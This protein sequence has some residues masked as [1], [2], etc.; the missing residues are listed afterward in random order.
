VRDP[1]IDRG[2][3]RRIAIAGA[4]LAAVLLLAALVALALPSGV[5][6]GPWLPL[7][8]AL[9]GGASLAIAAVLPFFSTTL[10]AAPPAPTPLRVAAMLL[11]AAGALVAVVGYPSGMSALAAVGAVVFATG[12]A[13]TGIAAFRPLARARRALPRLVLASYAVALIDV[14]LGAGLV[15]LYLAGW[16]PIVST[17]PLGMVAHAWLN[18]LGFVSLT[19]A[20]TLVHLLPTVLGTRIATRRSSLI[21]VVGLIVGA[22]LVAAG[23]LLQGLAGAEPGTAVHGLADLLSRAGALGLIAGAAGLAVFAGTTWR[24]RGRWTTDR[25]WH[26]WI[27][28]GLGSSITWFVVAALAAGIPVILLGAD[29]STWSPAT[30]APLLVGGWLALAVLGSIGH[31]LPSIG[32]GGPVR[33]ARQRVGLGRAAG[34]RLI[35]LD[36]G[37]VVAL[38]AGITSAA[39]LAA[40]AVLTYGVGLGSSLVLI[41]SALATRD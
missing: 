24:R 25:D 23:M 4:V 32:P 40:L 35:L 9:A 30:V 19:I 31:L 22:P 39:S 38:L 13:I 26:R 28:G 5:G 29:A 36:G 12:F 41:V 11:V 20:A 33:H 7:H 21:S 3:D 17:W 34:I 15:A 18:L 37:V 6:R 16:A 27:V 1:A 10:S 8:L 2:R 14:I